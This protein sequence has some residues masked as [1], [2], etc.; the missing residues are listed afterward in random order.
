MKKWIV[1]MTFLQITTQIAKSIA[2]DY[3]DIKLNRLNIGNHLP[4][5]IVNRVVQ[6]SLG[7]MWFATNNG[8]VRFDGSEC[9]IYKHN[10]SLQN[11]VYKNNLKVI[12]IDSEGVFWLAYDRQL[13]KF[14]PKFERFVNLSDG[15]IPALKDIPF[16]IENL[17][18]DS[19]QRIW[20]YE[21]N[22]AYLIID[23]K[24]D[25]LIASLETT[26]HFNGLKELPT[27]I[28]ED[29]D[30]YFWLLASQNG[31][32]RIQI[33][34]SQISV[35]CIKDRFRFDIKVP[36]R[37]SAILEDSKGNL[38]LANNG[39]YFLPYNKKN[40][41]E[42]EYIDIFG[43]KKPTCDKD[44]F[45]SDLVE[46]ASGMIWISSANYGIIRYN[47]E[48]K[49]PESIKYAP[50]NEKGVK[51]GS[52][53]FYLD[54]YYRLWLFFDNSIISTYHPQSGQFSE[55][56][57]DQTVSKSTIENLYNTSLN[58]FFFQKK[59]STYWIASP[60]Y[61]LHYFTLQNPVFSSYTY[62]PNNPN[63][64][65]GIPVWG[66][67]EDSFGYLWV[68]TKNGLNIIDQKTGRVSHHPYYFNPS[69]TK[70]QFGFITCFKQ[71]SDNEYWIGSTPMGRFRFNPQTK[72]LSLINLFRPDPTDSSS[73]SVWSL[74]Y[75][76]KDRKGDLWLGTNGGGLEQYLPPDKKHINGSFKHYSFNPGKKGSIAGSQVWHLMEDSKN[77]LWISTNNGISRLNKE[78][79]EVVN[80]TVLE[81]DTS[82]LNE[83]SVKQVLEDSKGRFW[84]ATEG[85]GL[86]QYLEKENRFVHYT[87]ANGFATN[88]IFSI[89]EDKHGYLWLSSNVGIIKYNPENGETYTFAKTND[90]QDKEYAAGSFFQSETSGTIYFGGNNG[91]NY[92]N[93]DSIK[94]SE[95]TP[96]IV[97]TSIVINNNEVRA[98]DAEGKKCVTSKAIPYADTII[99]AHH[100]SSFTIRFAALDFVMSGNIKY[101]YRFEE[102]NSNWIELPQGNNSLN[103]T[104]LSA[105]THTLQI[106]STNT[107]GIWCNNEKK[108]TIIVRPPWWATW[109]AYL[110]YSG[111]FVLL[112]IGFRRVILIRYRYQ[113]QIEEERIKS[114]R[115]E[116]DLKNKQIEFTKKEFELR[117]QQEIE[118]FK[119]NFFMNVSHELRTPITLILGPVE[120][121]IKSGL[122]AGRLLENERLIERNAKRLL[123]LVN[124]LLDMRKLEVGSM[125]LHLSQDN[126]HDF[127]LGIF[128]SFQHLAKH[129]RIQYQIQVDLHLE[130]LGNCFF[131][132][133]KLEKIMCNLLSNAFK[134]TPDE[135]F[136]NVQ[137]SL[138]HNHIAQTI[139]NITLS[140]K[141]SDSGI[142]IPP[143]KLA[144]IFNPFYQIEESDSSLIKRKQSGTGIGLSLTKE[145]VELHQGSI[146]ASSTK[147]KGSTF[148]IS[149]PL[150]QTQATHHH[151]CTKDTSPLLNEFH[152][153]THHTSEDI[154]LTSYKTAFEPLSTAG[155]KPVLLVVDDNPD[156]R[157]FI[158]QELQEN[159]SIIEAEN[160]I[161]GEEKALEFIPDVI[162]CDVMMPGLNGM[163]LTRH[164][165]NNEKT[166]HIP[167]ILLT[168]RTNH[169]QQL[170]GLKTGADDY[171]TKPFNS[172]VLLVR[173]TNQI[174]N[175][176][177][178]KRYLIKFESTPADEVSV[179]SLDLNFLK[180]AEA[181]VLKHLSDPNLGTE[182]LSCELAMSRTQ[183]YRKFRGLIGRSV[184]EYI[185]ITR[186]NHATK[187][188]QNESISI[189]EIA[190]IVGFSNPNNFSTSFKDQ[191]GKS[192]SEFRKSG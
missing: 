81:H 149:L 26:S 36:N 61:G 13:V 94:P 116:I 103:F 98:N 67:M 88:V 89:M 46:D 41:L 142:G 120:S 66:I 145:L 154:G 72:Q 134:F 44:F 167:I 107:Y 161:Q 102:T 176:E 178:I 158:T 130:Q 106:R 18:L 121:N 190:F 39:L 15:K 164:L 55:L 108:L 127:L 43:E 156:V 45:I 186:L 10:F 54:K 68:G 147:G 100:Q 191:F 71:V 133:D 175:R 62:V 82:S 101:A 144:F 111:F 117:K 70:E 37:V 168:A 137:L 104:L 155:E 24:K 74:L 76:F 84:I 179:N 51:G 47:P 40:K 135:G 2:S 136:I 180:K 146:T 140:I 22:F 163:E 42:F 77:R 59:T 172:E 38:Y 96:T 123:Q 20:I 151:L 14:Y 189:A 112:L 141:V 63:S 65:S 91:I 52:A 157:Q 17:F 173:I 30:G 126:L 132:P 28:I 125:Q 105:G 187:L 122:M 97:F 35:K 21:R 152:H 9:K 80:F 185:R 182:L 170:E 184:N 56:K 99:L 16:S 181:V 128:D 5:N 64:L 115:A 153:I 7:F 11:K 78:R 169:E 33:K 25:S 118:Q 48:T 138:E 174:K 148:I 75:I 110:L 90:I 58:K 57:F 3:S 31:L 162:L 12:C 159:Y 192:P 87:L 165:K 85:G 6:D 32:F 8:L 119:T 92:F 27:R 29:K 86:N 34:G 49:K 183:L 1:I 143:D 95:I 19:K 60:D 160:G 188:L 53:K 4:D 166:S 139:N 113:K 171:I 50:L 124:Q 109:W 129:H 83:F 79:T 73:I 114:A 93:P 131:D 69:P 177:R 150:N 23:S